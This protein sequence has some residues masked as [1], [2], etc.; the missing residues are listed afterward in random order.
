MEMLDRGRSL[1]DNRPIN[2]SIM[3]TITFESYV[4]TTGRFIIYEILLNELNYNDYHR[5]MDG[6]IRHRTIRSYQLLDY[7]I[8]AGYDFTIDQVEIAISAIRE[9]IRVLTKIGIKSVKNHEKSTQE[10]NG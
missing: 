9:N 6:P 2:Y 1:Y 7:L 10:L 8:E 4:T 3:S 5:L